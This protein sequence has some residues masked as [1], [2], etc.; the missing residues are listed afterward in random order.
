MKILKLFSFL[1]LFFILNGCASKEEIY[2]KQE[3][4]HDKKYNCNKMFYDGYLLTGIST[5][6]PFEE[7]IK[8]VLISVELG[9]MECLA[10]ATP[11]PHFNIEKIFLNLTEIQCPD[12]KKKLAIKGIVYDEKCDQGINA[13]HIVTQKNKSYLDAKIQMSREV[14]LEYIIKRVQA[15]FG[16]LEI[17]KN[18]KILIGFQDPSWKKSNREPRFAFEN[19]D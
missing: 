1:L 4:L 9:N 2:T 16:T 18:Q 3:P 19:N 14:S 15:E 5:T 8:P 17:E 12:M 10:L 11:E 7:E 13:K 6:L